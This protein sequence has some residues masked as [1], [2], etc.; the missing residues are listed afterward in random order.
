MSTIWPGWMLR[1]EVDDQLGKAVLE[2]GRHGEAMLAG[3]RKALHA[4]TA[5]HRAASSTLPRSAREPAS[6]TGTTSRS[7]RRGSATGA[8]LSTMSTSAC[9]RT[10]RRTSGARGP[11]NLRRRRSRGSSRRCASFLRFTLGPTNVPDVSLAP[12]RPRRLPD[13]PKTEEVESALSA[14]D[15]GRPARPAEPARSS[16][17]CIRPACAAAEA[18]GLDLADVDFDREQLHVARQGRQG[19]HRPARRRGGPSA[20]ALSPR[21]ATGAGDECGERAVP[22]RRAASGSTRRRCAA[23]SPTHTGCG[24]RSRRI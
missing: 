9:S 15:G 3:P 22:R 20:C 8:W 1:A 6:P 11:A 23:C 10:T 12:R 14:L 13:T 5:R 17:S 2:V 19:A 16:S 4:T 18:V 21:S 7:S 24:M